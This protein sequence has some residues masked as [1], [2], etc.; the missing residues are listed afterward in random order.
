MYVQPACKGRPFLTS[1]L[2]KFAGYRLYSTATSCIQIS[3]NGIESNNREIDFELLFQSCTKTHLA[4]CLHALI[5]VSGEAQSVFIST[6]LVNLYANLGDIF[7]SRRTFDHIPRKN[8]YAWNS[9]ISSNVRNGCFRDAVNCLYEMLMASKVRPDFYTFPTALKACSNLI[10]GKRIHSWVFKMGFQWDV[11]IA[12]SL[13]HMYCR[14]GLFRVA[15]EIFN[16]M[17]FRDM[18]CWNAIISGLCRHGNSVVVLDI[19]DEMRLEGIAMDSVTVSTI[20]PIC[21]QTDDIL[22]G[23]L[24]HL[25]VIKHGLEFDLFVGNA[26]I[27]M[28]AKFGKLGYAQQFFDQMEVR[29]LV[30][31]NSII[32]AYE[33]NDD[34]NTALN[35]YGAMQLNGIQPDFLTLVS[36]AS[37]VAQSKDSRNSSSIHA[38]ILKRCWI[39]EHVA[40]GNAVVDMYAKLGIVDSALKVFEELPSKDLISWNTM[41]TG[42]AQNGLASEAIEVYSMLEECNDIVPNEATWV[43]ILPAYAHVGGL[44]GGTKIHAR[45]LKIGLDV[46]VFVGTCLVDLYGKCGRLDDAMS[47]FDNVPR[48]SSVPWNAVISCHA[49]HGHGETSL[50]LFRNMLDEGVNPDHITFIS[51]LSACS[52]SGLV[53]QGQ[54]CFDLMHRKY[55]IKPS[56]KHYGCMVDLLGRAG[57]LDMAYD[58]IKSMPLKPDASIWGAL[59]GACRIHGNIELGNLASDRLFE[60]DS[61]NVGYYVL[62]S[63]MYANVGKWEELDQVRSLARERGLR[64][65]P[66]W[67]SMEVNNR[68]EVFYTGNQSHPQCEEIYNELE[69]L[70]AKMKSLG[71]V[72]DYSFVLQDVEEDE[73]QHILTSHS[74]RLAIAYGIISTPPKNP[75]RIFKNLRVCGD[76]HN[77]TKLISKITEREIIVR[78]SNRFHRFKDGVCSCGDYW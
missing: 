32:A 4:K 41:I 39:I 51:L 67:S 36:L 16:G 30:S 57:H 53:S 66:G 5:I 73:K 35:L 10:D 78:D 46:D 76:C 38:F 25:Y 44:R 63:N 37:S 29:D 65:T 27:N 50:Q 72:P 62:L 12:S 31:W 56:L 70:T 1:H 8:V 74:E 20:L 28:Y 2:L 26:L 17:P 47:L 24:I 52:H 69:I 23:I 7:L 34:P 33:Q 59:L 43:S 55:G 49:I 14:F 22:R 9:M 77:A 54:W 6:R 64:K 61:E 45:V 13:V 21:A 71:Y 68:V 60:V 58:F 11:F 75:I 40:I 48:V 15:H 3:T 19:L 42:Y 18:G